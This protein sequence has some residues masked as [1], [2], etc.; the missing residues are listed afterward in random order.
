MTVLS[1]RAS[2]GARSVLRALYGTLLAIV[3]LAASG[4]GNTTFTYGTPVISFSTTPGPFTS[5][6]V[7]VYQI[8][9]TRDDGTLVYP[10]TVPEMVDFTHLNDRTELFGAPAVIEG[11]Y[12][13]ATITINYSVA[14]IYVNVNGASQAVTVLDGATGTTAATLSYTVKFDPA[15][16]L[17]IKHGVSTPLDFNFDLSASSV[18]NTTTS[19]MQL[20]VR[21]VMTASTEP[22]YRKP[23]RARGEFVTTDTAGSNFTVNAR[24]FFDLIS[25]PKGAIQINTDSNTSYNING[26]SFKG[27][28]G[29]AALGKLAIN[30]MIEAYGSLD[31]N[32]LNSIKPV[33]TASE[34]YAGVSISN[35]LTDRIIGTVASRS[36]NTLHIHGAVNAHPI[37]D[38]VTDEALAFVND[39]PVTVASTTV[40]AVNGQ[41]D[42]ASPSISDISVGQQV[43]MEATTT[44][45]TSGVPTSADA[46]T[47]LIRLASSSAWGTLNAA[48]VPT[49]NLISLGNYQPE[50]FTFTGTGSATGADSD[51]N[52]Y[53][54]TN[55][56]GTDL[57]AAAANT[58]VRFDGMVTP[59]GSAPPD[60]TATAAALGS[61][62]DQ[63]LVIDWINGGSTSPFVSAASDGLTVNMSDANLGTSHTIQTGP[64]YIQ[65][66]ATTVDLTSPLVN[67]KIVADPTIT[68]QFAIGNGDSTTELS[69]FHSYASYLTQINTVLNGTNKIQKL[70]AVG[71][72]DGATF[73]AYRIDMVQLP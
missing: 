72:W 19:P 10:L 41:P 56:S 36:G 8:A 59:F 16:P 6:L 33:F 48:G 53:A 65:T 68:N 67:P 63:V 55:S 30:T 4:C 71:R 2:L 21:P 37:I 45:N 66:T 62:T 5:Y 23:M 13:S 51:P 47:G 43:D 61:G 29:L 64:M 28:D 54:I 60:L 70:V 17:A 22:V 40:V 73:T 1:G 69:V 27:A 49:V 34:V 20:T 42:F 46:S 15:H 3:G 18:L 14:Q 52:A 24:A 50:V 26:V 38:Y 35:G 7:Q 31:T 39:L 58:L 32:A 57:S 12:V 11:N 25:S 44:F 9:L